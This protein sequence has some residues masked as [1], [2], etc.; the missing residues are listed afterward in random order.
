MLIT[1]AAMK[2]WPHNWCV[3]RHC[4]QLRGVCFSMSR[5]VPEAGLDDGVADSPLEYW[6]AS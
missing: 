3:G 1:A 4:G 2:C 5:N 6:V